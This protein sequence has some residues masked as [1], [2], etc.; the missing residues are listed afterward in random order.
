[1]KG[2][3]KQ[4]TH[5][6]RAIRRLLIL[7]GG[8]AGWM[9]AAELSHILSENVE[10]HLVESM[11]V[12]TIGVGEATVPPIRHFNR[13]LGLDEPTFMSRTEATYKLGID[14]IDWAQTGHRYF[15]PF[16]SF[17]A[18]F[19]FVPL[20]AYWLKYFD[21]LGRPPLE[22]FSLAWRAAQQGRFDHPSPD[23]RSIQSTLDYAYHLD[24]ALYGDLLRDHAVGQGVQRSIGT[25]CGV[26]L[27]PESGF[28]QSVKLE[29]GRVIEA[30][31]FI[32]CSGF[33]SVLMAQSLEIGWEDW[34]HWLLSDRAIAVS[35]QPDANPAPY[36]KAIARAAGWQ[37]KIPLRHRT[38]NGYVYCSDYESEDDATRSLLETLDTAPNSD[39]RVL[40]FQTGRR[41]KFWHK[42][43]LA[44]GLA[45]GFMEPLESTSLHLVQSGIRRFLALFPDANCASVLVDKYNSLTAEEYRNIRDFLIL[46]YCTTRRTEGEIWTHYQNM[47][48]PHSLEE[49]IN[50]YQDYGRVDSGPLDLFQNHSWVSI[51]AGQCPRPKHLDPLLEYRPDLDAAGRLDRLRKNIEKA[52][53][54]MPPHADKLGGN[55]MES[56]LSSSI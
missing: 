3:V 46:H 13:D 42:N 16:G 39:P 43:C 53:Q 18:D 52:V 22:D 50:L 41:Q 35:S 36:T 54:L 2:S 44:L 4:E 6:T 55:G 34:S 5:D 48:I 23:R 40:R 28:I 56:R 9:A 11:S 30:D 10:I 17:G 12:G 8:S 20:H 15:H 27:N 24:A 29:D 21:V 1:M 51:F 14:F 31:L 19:D 26:S 49:K 32:D 37:W 38:G 7:G 33:R 45:A 47:P 25:V